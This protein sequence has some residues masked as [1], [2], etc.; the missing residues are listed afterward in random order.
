MEARPSVFAVP[1]AVALG[2]RTAVDSP[3]R[4]AMAAGAGAAAVVGVVAVVA[5][6]AVVA[7]AAAV[8]PAVEESEPESEASVCLLHFPPSSA[9]GHS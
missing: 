4:A 7:V 2:K 9:P 1:V 6:V 3:D 5:A 8:L